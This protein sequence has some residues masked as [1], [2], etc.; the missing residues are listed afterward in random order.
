[1]L[2]NGFDPLL[3]TLVTGV[4]GYTA[5]VILLRVSGK[6]TL[7]KWN[8]FDFVVTVAFGSTLASA[9]LSETT[10][11]VQAIVAFGV[12]IALQFIVTS[13]SVRSRE[14]ERLVKAEPVLLVEEGEL[15]RAAMLKERVT[16]AEILAALRRAGISDVREVAALV[17]ETDGSFSVIQSGSGAAEST[18]ADVRR[19]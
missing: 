14:I 11:T 12:L 4:L 3:R 2:F 7:A 19:A 9:L 13:A 18:L 6:R 10:S 16:N 5:L 17:L 8:A 15:R 1:M